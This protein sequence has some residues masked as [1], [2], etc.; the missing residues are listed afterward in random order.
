MIR[1]LIAA[2]LLLGLLGNLDRTLPE[3]LLGYAI[4]VAAILWLLWPMLRA[5]G[6]GLR[7]AR[8]RRR[9]PAKTL[10]A[11]PAVPHLTQI[12]HHHYYY[13]PNQVP[14]TPAMPPYVDRTLPALPQQT[15]QQ[16]TTTS[17]YDILDLDD[18]GPHR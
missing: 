13:G 9:R 5:I 16:R 10:A 14:P 18:E 11:V 1:T 17:I 6:R 3:V 4:V 8:R 7:R 15:E 2:L 12:T